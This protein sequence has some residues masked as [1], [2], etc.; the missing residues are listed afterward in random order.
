MRIDPDDVAL[1]VADAEPEGAHE[2]LPTS[3]PIVQTSLFSF[4]TFQALL[5]AFDDDF[6]GM[7]YTRGRNPTVRA[8]ERKLALLERAEGCCCF[9][10]GMA[11]VSAVMFGL[12]KAGDQVLLVNN[13]YGPTRKL[14]SQLG[15]FGVERDTVLDLDPRAVRARL[16]PNTRLVWVE[17]PSTYLFRVADVRQ[18]CA[19]AHEQGA[20][21]CCDNSW[22]TPLLQKPTLLGA[23]LV[24]HSATKYLAGHGDVVVGA[25]M[26]PKVSMREIYLRSTQLLGG[27]V[28]PFE[29]WLLLRGL[30]TLPVR[31]EQHERDALRVAEFLSSHPAVRAVHHPALEGPNDLAESQLRGYSGVFSFELARDGLESVQ[32]VIDGLRRFRIGVSWGGVESVVISPEGRSSRRR[33]ESLGIP[34]GLI[35]LSVGLEGAELLI[36]DLAAALERAR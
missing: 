26:G 11:A 15:R 17:S 34:P 1:C 36:A 6:E 7:T 25:V 35:R 16:R 21:V 10:S 2:P 19:A 22:A 23:D 14:A 32:R 4:P 9:A 12:L 18:I 28:A 29:A 33:L 13:V 31:L 5:A 20:L 27:V 8:V 24:V 30:R 3:P